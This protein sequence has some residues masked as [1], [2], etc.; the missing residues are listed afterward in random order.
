MVSG[1]ATKRRVL[2]TRKETS[3]S[4]RLRSRFAGNFKQERGEDGLM[5]ASSDQRSDFEKLTFGMDRGKEVSHKGYDT[6]AGDYKTSSWSDGGKSF[7]TNDFKDRGKEAKG[8]RNQPYFMT[9][10]FKESGVAYGD[11]GKNYKTSDSSYSGESWKYAGR[12]VETY[13]NKRVL[14]TPPVQGEIMD[15]RE[16]AR[17]TIEETNS[18]LGRKPS[19]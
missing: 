1:C 12:Q 10:Q 7:A 3:S 14:N 18:I 15:S 4:D 17:K 2:D 9:K 13:D 11:S 8:I 6:G 16:Y 5:H 19:E